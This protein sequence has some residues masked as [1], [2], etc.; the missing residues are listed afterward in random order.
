MRG[1]TSS[2]V[3]VAFLVGIYVLILYPR[4][5]G[6]A[7]FSV[8]MVIFG[9][10]EYERNHHEMSYYTLGEIPS[11]IKKWLLSYSAL[12][13]VGRSIIFGVLTVFI[14]SGTNV[15]R[16]KILALLFIA[17]ILSG[18]YCLSFL[19]RR[20]Y[21]D[22]ARWGYIKLSV[23]LGVVFSILSAAVPGMPITDIVLN[24]AK[25]KLRLHTFDEFAELFYGLLYQLNSFITSILQALFGEWLGLFLSLIISVNVVYGFVVLLYSLLLFRILGINMGRQRN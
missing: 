7:T 24:A 1:L 23:L 15:T 18:Y 20:A 10:L 25:G 13:V 12:E 5:F 19:Q 3:V 2:A 9:R 6:L 4:L 22:V 8:S 16:I 17:T 11:P 14:F 21:I